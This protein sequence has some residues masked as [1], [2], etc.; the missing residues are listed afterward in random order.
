MGRTRGSA[1]GG[2]ALVAACATLAAAGAPDARSQRTAPLPLLS[3]PNVQIHGAA[4]TDRAGRS[5]S[6][7][8]DVNGDGR[9]DVI[10]GAHQADNNG[11]NLSGS[12]Y[13]V[14]GQS[15]PTTVDLAAL[16]GFGFRIDG[17]A[18]GDQAGLSVAGTGDV[19]GD[20]LADVLVGAPAP[21][22]NTAT[23]WAY[24]VFGK[25]STAAVDLAALG[26]A[27]F[28]ID[29]SE[30]G[31]GAGTGVSGAGDQNGDGRADVIVGAPG[32]DNKGVNGTGAAYVVFGKS[33]TAAVDLAAL[34]SSG[35]R[36][37]GSLG[38]HVGESVSDAGDV[39]GDGRTDLLVGAPQGQ[40]TNGRTY[41]VFGQAS[42]VNIDLEALGGSG[43][44]INGVAASENAGF[45]VSGAGDVNGDARS[46]VLLVAPGA[47]NNGRPGSGS[48]F[49][50]F[51]KA[52]TTAVELSTLG[53]SGFRID[54]PTSGDFTSAVSSAGDV[55]RDGL[56]DALIGAPGAPNSAGLSSGSAWVVYGKSSTA[57][58]DLA[59]LGSAGF[60]IDGDAAQDSAGVS[61]SDAGDV[62]GDGRLEVLVGASLADR[63][64]RSSSGS[65]YVVPVQAGLTIS[66]A[67]VIEGDTGVTNVVF[68]VTASPP[69][70]IP[71]TFTASTG[72]GTASSGSDFTALSQSYT[73][74]PPGQ[75][76]AV[77][78][79]V[80]GDTEVEP[81]ETFA[82][83]L[84]S[85][86]NADCQDCESVGVIQNDD[87]QPVRCACKNVQAGLAGFKAR[88]TTKLRRAGGRAQ[89]AEY[90]DFT[91]KGT[92]T[93]SPGDVAGC[94]GFVRTVSPSTAPPYPTQKPR[95][96]TCRGRNCRATRF[97]LG[98]RVHVSR[99]EIL[100]AREAWKKS[101][102]PLARKVRLRTGCLGA[103]GRVRTYTL[104]FTNGNSFSRALSDQDGNGKPDRGK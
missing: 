7:A 84:S 40:H 41:V 34:G 42:P 26:D 8:G 81:G 101:R 98:V 32:A 31:A 24:V 55:N 15:T 96:F 49:V 3:P 29:G 18:A 79:Q 77:A 62:N 65:A 104:V 73:I 12:V 43:F 88:G 6:G 59:A 25:S 90:W 99:Q 1:A 17:A 9:A 36:L 86:Q 46:D 54:G 48:A 67:T 20:G 28:R 21:F 58:V 63:N 85:V 103:R 87:A 38:D 66:D 39:N 5:V 70:P 93:C 35:F 82:V 51:G 74:Q 23:G 33:S 91:V 27:G 83:T 10:V 16:G 71:V 75:A 19:N 64:G 61:V 4:E 57:T 37:D 45:Q 89:P 100:A 22:E 102:K 94:E 44:P 60:Q 97:A 47:D 92:I 69:I 56:A 2:L 95:S 30:V 14:F 80:R 13:V 53:D 72:S 78:V 68:T 50:V 11:R 52:T 76:V